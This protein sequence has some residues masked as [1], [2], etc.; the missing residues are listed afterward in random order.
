MASMTWALTAAGWLAILSGSAVTLLG[1]L[2]V[3]TLFLGRGVPVSGAGMFAIFTLGVGPLLVVAGVT[4]AIAGYRVMGGYAW[5]RS[6][7]EIFSW[8]ALVSAV[9]WL[10]YSASEKRNIHV[11]DVVQGAIFLLFTGVPAIALILL[12]RSETVQRAMNR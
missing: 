9:V 7:L 4:I 3:G 8:I 11:I 5:A 2:L 10:I 1:L 6:A 12:L